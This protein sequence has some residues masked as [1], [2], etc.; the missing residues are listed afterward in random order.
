VC[1]PEN[2]RDCDSKQTSLTKNLKPAIPVG[3]AAASAAAAA[4]GAGIEER[5]VKNIVDDCSD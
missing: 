2:S 3:A 1:F 5:N 4:G